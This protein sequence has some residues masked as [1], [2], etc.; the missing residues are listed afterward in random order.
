MGE[1]LSILP[2][3]RRFLKSAFRPTVRT[4]SLT[5]AR[6]NGKNTFTTAVAC[7][8]LYGPIAVPRG[9]VVIVASSFA[10]ARIIFDHVVAFLKPAIDKAPQDWA[11]QDSANVASI[12]YKPLGTKLVA[13]GSDPRRADGLA[14]SL[15][16][17]DEPSQWVESTSNKMLS[18]LQ[19]SLGK[20]PDSRM[21]ALGTMPES[22]S[23]WF[24]KW[25]RGGC[26]YAQ[27]HAADGDAP[28]FKRSTWAKANPSMAAMPTLAEAIRSDANRAKADSQALQS[29]RALRL[30]AGVVD[31]GASVVMD[32]ET[33]KS[34]EVAYLPDREGGYCL[35]LD[36]GSNSAMS[37]AAGY[38]PSSHRLEV[39][40]Y[41][42]YEPDFEARG[43]KDGVGIAYTAKWP[44]KTS[45]GRQAGIQLTLP[46]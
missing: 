22:E 9:E 32:A 17:A 10:Q 43:A 3:Q 42:P 13:K 25:C 44:K 18:A 36:L 15:V 24:A 27:V 2:W 37:G 7:A 1:P 31:V 41:F 38:W 6:G 33:W 20:Q 21:V 14:P 46:R 11:V 45:C 8:A 28:P 19:T 16:L 23:H 30:N 39:C 34:S 4:V 5:V 29:F 40:A 26:D 35:G 12:R